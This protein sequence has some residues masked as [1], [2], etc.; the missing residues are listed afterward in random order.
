MVRL[1]GEWMGGRGEERVDIFGLV[2]MFYYLI[3]FL[4][5]WV[6]LFSKV[7]RFM[8]LCVFY[9]VFKEVDFLE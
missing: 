4:F 8:C 7:D 9:V 1:Y 6:W 2:V 5:V 3:M